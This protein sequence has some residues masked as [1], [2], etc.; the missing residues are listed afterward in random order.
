[1][2]IRTHFYKKKSFLFNIPVYEFELTS[3]KFIKCTISIFRFLEIKMTADTKILL[4]MNSKRKAD[5]WFYQHLK[6][7]PLYIHIYIYICGWGECVC[8]LA[9]VSSISLHKNILK[10]HIKQ[11]IIL[12]SLG[13]FFFPNMHFSCKAYQTNTFESHF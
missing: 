9:E 12:Q 7:Y 3:W 10:V 8:V 6:N 13:I 4:K 2:F 5:L 11:R 1:M